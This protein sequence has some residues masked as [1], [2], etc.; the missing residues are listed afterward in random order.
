M[1]HLAEQDPVLAW[2]LLFSALVLGL[3][4]ALWVLAVVS[5][6][7]LQRLGAPPEPPEW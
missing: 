2:A 6:W 1:E 7:A 3:P 5:E 4:L